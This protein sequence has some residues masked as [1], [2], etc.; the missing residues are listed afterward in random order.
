MSTPVR[1]LVPRENALREK[2]HAFFLKRVGRYLLPRGISDF[3]RFAVNGELWIALAGEEVV[4]TCYIARPEEEANESEDDSTGVHEF[5]GIIVDPSQAGKGLASAIG[6]VALAT[7]ALHIAAPLI[8]H[9]HVE[10]KEPLVVLTKWL[11]FKMRNEKPIEV[12]KS[13]LEKK[14]GMIEMKADPDGF[15]R[16]NTFDFTV[17]ELK[18]FA[19]RLES[20]ALAK[21]G[22]NVESQYLS[23][24]NLKESVGLLREL[25]A[26]GTPK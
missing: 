7:H 1:I 26:A 25:A 12:S 15:I 4:A 20:G 16:G 10:N 21:I 14:H 5:G 2:T 3:D 6:T 11:G 24:T 23:G 13:E 9:V 18:T 19:D 17:T 8:S 22:V